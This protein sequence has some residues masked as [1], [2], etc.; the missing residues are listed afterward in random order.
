MIESLFRIDCFFGKIELEPFKLQKLLDRELQQEAVRK[1][2]IA[3]F[4]D[5][6]KML[7]I[8]RRDK[9]G[10][11]L[12]CIRWYRYFAGDNFRPVYRFLHRELRETRSV[13]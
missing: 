2:I 7:V 13:N 9:E 4:N 5:R 11:S 1:F 8:A 10:R 6:I 3:E 12:P